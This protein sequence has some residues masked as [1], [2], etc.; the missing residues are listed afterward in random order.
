[1]VRQFAEQLVRKYLIKLHM[2]ELI[3]E[4]IHL[5]FA[6]TEVDMAL[7]DRDKLHKI[8]LKDQKPAIQ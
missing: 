1:M 5:F 8:R 7:V 2:H 6:S 4:E 3:L